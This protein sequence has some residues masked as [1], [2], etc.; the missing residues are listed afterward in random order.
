MRMFFAIALAVLAAAS[1]Y[2]WRSEPR[3]VANGITT[4]VW[5]TDDNP[6]RRAQIAPFG[7]EF[8]RDQITLDPK[9]ADVDKVIIQSLAGVGP[10]LFDCYD[11][12]QLM[13][14]VRSGVAWDV[15]DELTK[16]HVDVRAL[17]WP[18]V[19]PDCIYEGRVYGF[20]VNAAVDGIWFNKTFFDESRVAYPTGPWTWKQLVT[21]AQKVVRH[22][23]SGKITRF[24]I[25]MDWHVTWPQFVLQWGG[26][27]YSPDGKT[28]TIDSPEAIAGI[29]FMQDL[30]YKYHVAPDP[31][32]EAAI[33]AGGGWGTTGSGVISLF[34]GGHSAMALGGRYWLCLM[35]SLPQLHVGAAECPY[36]DVRIFRG[37]GK[38]T[39]INKNSPHRLEALHW[40]QYES[41]PAY[42]ELINQQADGVAPVM[43]YVQNEKFLRDPH[44]PDETYNAIWANMQKLAVGDTP[45]PYVAGQ[46]SDRI[47]MEQL[48]LVKENFKAVPDAMHDAAKQINEEIQREVEESPELKARCD[49]NQSQ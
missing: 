36:H 45:S 13:A 38:A 25:L 19:W 29:Q 24:G 33:S 40:L 14:Y 15:T 23:A 26:H 12:Q 31:V 22:D 21:L 7:K 3:A 17:T 27:L 20:P 32:Q 4:L 49:G 9:N 11:P 8:P 30:I 34:T 18:A 42:N 5:T 28:C 6:L 43:K 10:D 46:I 2:A 47:V 37:Y 16:M 1:I 35:R 41:S 48:D 39:L 44:H